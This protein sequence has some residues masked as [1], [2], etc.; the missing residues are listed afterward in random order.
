MTQDTHPHTSGKRDSLYLSQRFTNQ[1]LR[2]KLETC[3]G[4][5]QKVD[6][7]PASMV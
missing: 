6:Q 5:S 4:R 7:N 3:E 2:R 1:T